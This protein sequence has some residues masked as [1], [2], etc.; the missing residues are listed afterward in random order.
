[1]Q[2]AD[3]SALQIHLNSLQTV[4]HLKLLHYN[5]KITLVKILNAFNE[6]MRTGVHTASR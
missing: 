1:M 5:A 4:N 2:L 3:E 6:D